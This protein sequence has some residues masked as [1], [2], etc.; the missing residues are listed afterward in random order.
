MYNPQFVY[1]GRL[2]SIEQ[3][4]ASDRHV[5]RREYLEQATKIIDA[6]RKKYGDGH[7]L[8]AQDP[9]CLKR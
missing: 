5:I 8:K 1:K 6:A 7:A 2:A 4:L 3:R 9:R